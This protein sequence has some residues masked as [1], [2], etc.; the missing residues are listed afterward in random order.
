MTVNKQHDSLSGLLPHSPWINPL[1][2]QYTH[3]KKAM[4][5]CVFPNCSLYT[6]RKI[7]S[8]THIFSSEACFPTMGLQ[9]HCCSHV[10]QKTNSLRK[11][12]QIAECS[13]SH[14]RAQGR[15]SPQPRAPTSF[16]ENLL[17]L[18]CTCPNPPP[19]IPWNQSEQRQRKIQSKLTHD[20]YALSLG[21]QQWTITNRPVVIPQ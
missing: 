18:K 4:Q 17:Y 8:C 21:S 2:F 11:T 3:V 10:F 9:S 16:C 15:V 20:L 5:M 7:Q 13:L 1:Q 19:Q 6:D 12:M 14:Q